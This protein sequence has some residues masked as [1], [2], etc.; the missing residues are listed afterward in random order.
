MKMKMRILKLKRKEMMT[1]SCCIERNH[2]R[3]VQI[4]DKPVL[5]ML[6]FKRWGSTY[7]FVPADFEIPSVLETELSF[8]NA[9][10]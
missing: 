2:R 6:V 3:R 5:L 9:H 4:Y 1:K 8:A 7:P 10:Y